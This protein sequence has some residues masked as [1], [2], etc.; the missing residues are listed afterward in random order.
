MHFSNWERLLEA[1]YCCHWDFWR[2]TTGKKCMILYSNWL[3]QGLVVAPYLMLGR[4]DSVHYTHLTDNIFR[5]MPFHMNKTAGDVQRVHGVDERVGTQDY[6][7]GVKFYIRILQL[8][9]TWEEGSYSW[10]SLDII[11]GLWVSNIAW[12]FTKI[13]LPLRFVWWV[14][15][16]W[17]RR[18]ENALLAETIP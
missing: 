8:S 17:K 6:L 14:R 7:Q 16:P 18:E 9:L 10:S 3:L 11:V 13:L 15:S 1:S 4:T 2:R 12:P 5:F